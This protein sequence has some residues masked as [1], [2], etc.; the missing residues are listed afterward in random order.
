MKNLFKRYDWKKYD[1]TLIGVVVFLTMIGAFTVRL[2]DTANGTNFFGAQIKGL[3]MGM[4]IVSAVSLIDYHFI[5]KFVAIY[6]VFGVLLVAATRYTPLG[7]DLDTDTYR[8]LKFGSINFQPTELAKIIVILTL[9]VYYSKMRKKVDRFTTLLVA[10]IISLL[11]ILFIMKQPDL[12]SSL[13]VAFIFLMIMFGAGTSYKLLVPILAVGLP[14]CGVLFWYI[15]Q[16]FQILL[17]DYQQKRVMTFLYPETDTS[18]ALWQQ[19]NSQLAIASGQLYGKFLDDGGSSLR[20]YLNVPVIESDFIWS[21]I[22]EEYGFLGGVLILVLYAILI[23]KCLLAAKKAQDRLGM[24]I[25]LG[26]SA[27]FTFQV[28]ANIGVATF[29]L[30]NTG[31]PL[32]FLSNGLSSMLSCMIAIGLIINITIQPAKP[33]GGGFSM[34]QNDRELDL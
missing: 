31:L 33:S 29:M 14:S 27:L 12:S 8:W 3:I 20:N 26:I 4:V 28:F 17:K 13:V 6:Y 9:A 2:A 25:A 16:P 7:T 30:P 21:V 23:F 5:C 19:E 32:P 34:R 18:G 22:G 11:P 10:G 24:L 1:Y 15:Q